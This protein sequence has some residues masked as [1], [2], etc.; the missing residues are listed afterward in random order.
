MILNTRVPDRIILRN[1]LYHDILRVARAGVF[2][3]QR[4][5]KPV[6]AV[7][8][9]TVFAIDDLDLRLRNVD[10]VLAFLGV[11]A[12]VF[13]LIGDLNGHDRRTF[14]CA[15]R[16]R[17]IKVGVKFAFDRKCIKELCIQIAAQSIRMTGFRTAVGPPPPPPEDGVL[18]PVI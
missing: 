8:H 14:R 11:C 6:A 10:R 15:R 17:E 16:D 9:V 2:Y 4:N 13:I 18:P 3:G 7:D 12:A 5:R 1:V